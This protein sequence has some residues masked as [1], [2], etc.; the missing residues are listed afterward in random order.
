M[1]IVEDQVILSDALK[2]RLNEEE[3]IEVKDT[4]R[5]ASLAPDY[6]RKYVPDL[7]LMD[8][9]TENDASGIAA[10]EL[11]KKHDPDIFIVLMTGVPDITYLDR[12][13][14]IGV[15]SF[16]YKKM[17]TE[18]LISVIRSTMKGYRTYPNEMQN[19][20]KSDAVRLSERELEILKLF[21]MGK[22]RKEIADELG[23]KETTVK[24]LISRMLTKTDYSSMA[25]LVAFALAN[26]YINP[27]I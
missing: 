7:V 15:E 20:L 26:G 12:A 2:H 16:V 13:R 23:V 22:S 6:C 10:A 18:E 9:C 25:K 8:V 19:P 17:D 14:D 11:I 24:T 5:D 27:K 3:D 4:L 21:C 1:I